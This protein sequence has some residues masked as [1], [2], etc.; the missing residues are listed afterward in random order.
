MRILFVGDSLTDAHRNYQDPKDLGEGYCRY[1]M[2]EYPSNTEAFNRGVNGSVVQDV[3][4]RFDADCEEAKPD[5]ISIFVGINDMW[6]RVGKPD[7]GTEL[8][9]ERF[10][11]TYREL[12]KKATVRGCQVITVE[13]F[14]IPINSDQRKWTRD[15]D[16]KRKAIRELAEEFEAEFV[17]LNTAMNQLA[18]EIGIDKLTN[19]GIHVKNAGHRLIAE[20]WLQA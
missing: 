17:S 3:L 15:L 13:P 10:R 12:L 6:S 18:E 4:E 7:F 8:S 1:I 20:K 2:K 16:P 11:E 5:I 19:D 14:L 9:I